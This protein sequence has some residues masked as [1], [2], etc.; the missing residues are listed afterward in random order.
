MIGSTGAMKWVAGPSP[1]PTTIFFCASSTMDLSKFRCPQCRQSRWTANSEA[2]TCDA[3]GRAYPCVAGIPKLFLDEKLAAKDRNLRD[4][5]YNG[6]FGAL[7]R[8]TMP[9]LNLPSRPLKL[10][11][12]YW[13]VFF[14]TSSACA[15][16][17]AYLGDLVF[18]RR[19]TVIRSVDVIILAATIAVGF[20]FVR[21]AYLFWLFLLAIPVK[22]S[23]VSKTFNPVQSFGTVHARA[24]EKLKARGAV[25]RVLDVSTG[26]CNSLFRHGWMGLNAEFTGVDLSET[27][28]L[29]G[30]RFMADHGLPIDLAL[31]SATDLPFQSGT[32]DV[33]MSYGAINSM[34]DP[35]LALKEMARV[36]KVGAFILFLD[37]Q[38]YGQASWIEKLYFRRVLSSHNVIHHCPVEL[39]PTDLGEVDVHQVYQFYYICTASKMS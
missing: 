22:I 9:F 7:Y 1:S 2:W 27:M 26:S 14:L 38:L 39:L 20:F 36:A 6:L 4:T 33:V 10:S 25:L 5:F 29:Q 28:L 37:E 13:L 24:I 12:A 19:F 34:S 30:L 17:L 8:H 31:A 23:L 32:F 16:L 18:I 35:E 11:W 21:H 3:C 15:A